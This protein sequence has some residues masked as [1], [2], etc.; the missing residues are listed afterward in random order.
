M[1][2]RSLEAGGPFI[3]ASA[4]GTH[5]KQGVAQAHLE[6]GISEGRLLVERSE[7]LFG[8][9]ELHFC[10][11]GFVVQCQP[12]KLPSTLERRHNLQASL[13]EAYSLISVRHGAL[14][15]LSHH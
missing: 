11:L 8:N 13:K 12:G 10:H 1:A 7:A 14:N 6:I 9:R 5:T 4:L 15:V 3:R 2:H